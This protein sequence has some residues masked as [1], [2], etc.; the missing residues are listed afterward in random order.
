VHLSIETPTL[1]AADDE[2]KPRQIVGVVTDVRDR[3]VYDPMPVVYAPYRQHL[4]ESFGNKYEIHLGKTLVIRTTT[5]PMS[6]A[7]SVRGVVSEIDKEQVVY[8]I[9]TMKRRLSDNL[10]EW[11]FYMRL[12]SI[13]AGL[14]VILAAVGIYGVTSY[15]VGRR[16]HEFGIRMA[17]GARRGDVLRMVLREGLLLAGIGLV[18][19]LAAAFGLTRLIA[20]QLY[21]IEPTDPSTFVAVSLTLLG[22]ALLACYVP[23]RRAANVDPMAALR[24]E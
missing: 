14:A 17:L 23:A 13:F 6:L 18:I 16:T 5:N 9:M 19:G 3:G 15:S 12:Y 22:I 11:R 20:N 21:G 4:W 8:D 2:A 1:R 24:H 7:S 10:G